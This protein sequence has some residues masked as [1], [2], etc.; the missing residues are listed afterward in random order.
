VWGNQPGWTR[1]DIVSYA[2]RVAALIKRFMQAR[3]R[4]M[5]YLH[6]GRMMR[7]LRVTEPLPEVRTTWRKCDTPEHIQ[8]AVLNSVWR[9]PNRPGVGIVLVNIADQQ[10]KIAYELD[11]AECELPGERFAV[12][13]IDTQ[14]PEPLGERQGTVLRRRDTV[15]PRDVMILEVTPVE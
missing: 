8:P 5:D 15:S 14:R 7:P 3:Y 1:A 4:A 12:S 9:A 6:F 10:Q 2:P 13:R 11:L